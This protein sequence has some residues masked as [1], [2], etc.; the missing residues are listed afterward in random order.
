MPDDE[1]R[2]VVQRFG[3]N[4][5]LNVATIALKED[6]VKSCRPW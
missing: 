1:V 2:S 3:I 5:A 6:G 4:A